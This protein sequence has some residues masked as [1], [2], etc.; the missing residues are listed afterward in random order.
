[1]RTPTGLAFITLLVCMGCQRP[2]APDDPLIDAARNG[3]D[4]RVG[5][6]LPAGASPDGPPGR[7]APLITALENRHLSTAHLLLVH[8][9]GP[10]V[11]QP[12]WGDTALSLAFENHDLPLVSQLLTKG[13]TPGDDDAVIAAIGADT[14]VSI[15]KELLARGANAKHVGYWG[16]TALHSAASQGNIE[17]VRLLLR[18]G[19][20][21]NALDF[22]G[23]T[24]LSLAALYGRH[25]VLVYLRA[26]GADPRKKNLEGK[27]VMD[28][29]G[30][31]SG[32]LRSY[33]GRKSG[34]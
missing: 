32:L 14:P 22:S 12:Y 19:A 30:D 18:A 13:A 20:D 6:L 29:V 15:L 11:R 16:K 17:A 5:T 25:H 7:T 31:L 27:T 4:A 28:K 10:N 8:G 23:D 9:A 33:G 3:D 34:G 2:F 24:P 1:M 26:H 21:P